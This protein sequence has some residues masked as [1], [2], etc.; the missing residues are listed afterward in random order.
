M[1]QIY[2]SVLD[3]SRNRQSLR[4]LIEG[5]RLLSQ[6]EQIANQ[7]VEMAHAEKCEPARVGALKAAAD[8]K[9]RQLDKVLPDLKHVEH[10]LGEGLL[11]LKDAD[12]H[13]RINQL[14]GQ[15]TER[16]LLNPGVA[17]TGDSAAGGPTTVQ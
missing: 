7:L 9:L 4:T 6:V 17:G 14:I 12:L 2:G 16:G 8:L 11:A 3:R 5:D 13:A 10:D 1:A 15:L